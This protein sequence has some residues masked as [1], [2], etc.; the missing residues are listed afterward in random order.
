MRLRYSARSLVPGFETVLFGWHDRD[1]AQIEYQLPRLIVFI[2][3]VH[4]QGNAAWHGAESG[5][6]LTAFGRIVRLARGKRKGYGSPSIR[7]NQMN[8]GVPSAARFSNGLRSVFFYAPVPSGCTLI[9]VE[10]S[11]KASMRM[12]TICFS[13][14]RAKTR[15]RTPLFDQRFM[16]V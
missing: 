15:S 4:D 11:E 7:G 14:R 3:A 16:R 2:G 10:S 9:E 13:C 1:H 12:R 6:Q 8:L 5:Q